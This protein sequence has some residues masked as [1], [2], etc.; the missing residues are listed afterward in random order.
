MHQF[1]YVRT[2]IHTH[3]YTGV[4]KI[5]DT[6]YEWNSSAGCFKKKAY[7]VFLFYFNEKV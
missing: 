6:R 1:S 7:I 3:A 2:H 4:C 5:E